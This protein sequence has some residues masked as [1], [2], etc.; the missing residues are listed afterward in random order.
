M[1]FEESEPSGTLRFVDSGQIVAPAVRTDD[2]QAEFH[3]SIVALAAADVSCTPMDSAKARRAP[4]KSP[5][6]TFCQGVVT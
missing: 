5:D 4:A 2:C 6:H 3:C 1:T